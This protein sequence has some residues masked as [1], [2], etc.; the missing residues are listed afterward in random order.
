MSKTFVLFLSLLFSTNSYFVPDLKCAQ[1]FESNFSEST[2]VDECNDEEGFMAGTLVKTPAGYT[3]IQYL[4]EGDEIIGYDHVNGVQPKKVLGVSKKKIP[5]YVVVFSDNETILAAPTQK[6]YLPE[7][8]AWIEAQNIVPAQGLHN[9]YVNRVDAI[10]M[11]M[12]CYTLSVEDHCF[13]VTQNDILVH[14]ADALAQAAPVI[15]SVIE[16]GLVFV[17][18]PGIKM[19]GWAASAGLNI[20]ALHQEF[21]L[22]NSPGETPYI[23]E[24]FAYEN[25]YKQL[26]GMRDEFLAIKNGLEIVG[27]SVNRLSLTGPLLRSIPLQMNTVLDREL[28]MSISRELELNEAQRANLHALRESV[29]NTL[30][31]QILILQIGIASHFNELINAKNKAFNEYSQHASVIKQS[32]Q[33]LKAYAQNMPAT[34]AMCFYAN[35]C[36]QEEL[37]AHLTNRV[38]ELKL[39]MQYYSN[40]ANALILKSTTNILDLI[41]QETKTITSINSLISEGQR[42]NID[43]QNVIKNWLIGHNISVQNIRDKTNIPKQRERE[44]KTA[45][46][47]TDAAK[48]LGSAKF[49]EGPKKDDKHAPDKDDDSKLPK[50]YNWEKPDNINPKKPFR[51][52]P[53]PCNK[54]EHRICTNK[55]SPFGGCH[56]DKIVNNVEELFSHLSKYSLALKFKDKCGRIVSLA[57]ERLLHILK[58]H[59]PRYWDGTRTVPQDFFPLEACIEDVINLLEEALSQVDV[60]NLAD[61]AAKTAKDL[62]GEA[63]LEEAK[64]MIYLSK[65]GKSIRSFFPFV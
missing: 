62:K 63:V 52:D 48:R 12:Y 51:Q 44:D 21:C 39:V 16:V 50:I 18:H 37:I 25:I 20:Y 9:F 40:A 43:Y 15:V 13:Y 31:Q 7:Q 38:Q 27:Q 61:T 10:H 32:V 58:R 42:I 54:N 26:V 36:I 55:Q 53:K 47:L 4:S 45:R 65:D 3:P 24:R 2:F 14:N 59:L 57:V 64:Y 60:T 49:P 19:L 5:A 11:P 17:K 56:E 46:D 33:Q 30:E 1:S 35:L 28:S 29:L 6:F 8:N 34:F 23:P 41:E 22:P